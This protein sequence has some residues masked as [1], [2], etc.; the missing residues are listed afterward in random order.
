MK[1]S[2]LGEVEPM[3]PHHNEV[4]RYRVIRFEE[5]VVQV[6]NLFRAEN[7]RDLVINATPNWDFWEKWDMTY[8][9]LRVAHGGLSKD[10]MKV[11]LLVKGPYIKGSKTRYARLLDIFATIATYY[12]AV[13]IV[14]DTHAI[15]R[16]KYSESTS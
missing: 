14:R 16:M 15:D 10:E 2:P 3:K 13:R 7:C 1:V 8:R 11:F 6:F 9:T 5:T 12:N 4:K